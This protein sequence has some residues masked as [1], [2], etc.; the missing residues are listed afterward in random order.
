[1]DL[2]LATQ[3]DEELK[4]IS[5]H[6]NQALFIVNNSDDD[7]LK[8]K[9]RQALGLAIA[10]IDLEIWELIY[11]QHPSLRPTEMIPVGCKK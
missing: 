10:E 11:S 6:A 2:E 1:M 8:N 9:T 7:N 4:A 3:L 5:K